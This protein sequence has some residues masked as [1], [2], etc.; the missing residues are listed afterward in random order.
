M[1]VDDVEHNWLF[2]LAQ[3]NKLLSDIES[4]TTSHQLEL[5]KQSLSQ[6]EISERKTSLTNCENNSVDNF[7]GENEII[8]PDDI[9]VES[10]RLFKKSKVLDIISLQIA[11]NLKFNL[12]LFRVISEMPIKL[13]ARLYRVLVM[14]TAKFSSVLQPLFEQATNKENIFIINPYGYYTWSQLNP[15]TI[16]G[17]MSYHI[18]CLHVSHTSS[19]LPQP[20][21]NLTPI[22]SGLK[23]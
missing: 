14:N 3:P 1:K 12:N 21:R 10:S 17:I 23:S 15:M 4:L 19:M 7:I 6:A 11:A 9:F 18:W 13:L 20:F 8:N 2:Y 16:Y 5:L 22:V